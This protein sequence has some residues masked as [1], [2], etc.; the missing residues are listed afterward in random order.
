VVFVYGT[1]IGSFL[2]V[3]IYRIPKDESIINPPSHCPKC[4]TKLRGLDL[5]P[6]LSF[7]A[8]G[9]KCRYCGAP[10]GWR[11]FTVELITG[12]VFVA[13]F[14][15]YKFQID[16]FTFALF[17]AALI[18]IFFID[19]DH[20]IIPDQLSVFGIALGVGRDILGFVIGEKGHV[21]LRIHIPFTGIEFPMLW[22]IAGLVVCGAIFYA[23]AIFGE[24]AFKKEAMGGGD[25][26]LAAAIGAVFCAHITATLG[27]GLALLSFFIAV[28][29]GSVVGIGMKILRRGSGKENYLPFG[30][31]MVIGVVITWFLGKTIIDLY[32][33]Y[34]Q[35]GL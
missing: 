23:I 19:L 30:P 10:I 5:V 31:M 27:L 1:V 25:I 4:N 29:V 33:G 20:W 13:L 12:L 3:C 22:S 14:A 6:L 16:F 21:L 35:R 7:L 26:K 24:L 2:N 8:L 28:F 15:R 11:Y 9:R 17:A 34:L 18:A 32:M